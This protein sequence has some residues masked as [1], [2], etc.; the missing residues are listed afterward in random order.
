MTFRPAVRILTA[1][2]LS[3]C[4]S[5]AFAGEDAAQTGPK[6]QEAEAKSE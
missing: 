4:A 1:I 5:F 2:L 3:V 6:P